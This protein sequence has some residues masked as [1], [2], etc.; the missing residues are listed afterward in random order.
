MLLT[1]I[2]S[3]GQ[4]QREVHRHPSLLADVAG[5]VIRFVVTHLKVSDLVG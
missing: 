4:L 1:E 2:N 5:A 3:G